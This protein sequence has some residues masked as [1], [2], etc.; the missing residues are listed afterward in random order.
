MKLTKTTKNATLVI[1]ILTASLVNEYLVKL[2]N[3]YYKEGTFLSV[4][5]GMLVTVLIFVPMFGFVRS[6]M[7]KASKSY[8]KASKKIANKNSTGLLVGFSIAFAILFVLFASV[9]HNIDVVARL[10][11]LLK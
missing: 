1:S 6:V 9:R 2:V 10:S 8:L 3:S 7:D 11:A 4:L 5:T